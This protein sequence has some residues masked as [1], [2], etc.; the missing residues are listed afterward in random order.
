MTPIFVVSTGRCGST[1]LSDMIRR[2]PD[3]LSVS[4]F[5]TSL[6]SKAFVHSRAEWSGEAVYQRLNRLSPGGRALLKNGLYPDEFLYTRES[7]GRYR[8][9]EVP[10]ILCATLPHLSADSHEELWDELASVIRSRPGGALADHYRFVFEWLA[11]RFGKKT[12]IERS[13]G[14]LLYVPAL[15][16]LFPDARF[17]H[18]YRDGRDTAM[19]M[20][21]HP[22]FRLRVQAA[23]LLRR[24]GMNPFT[25][26]NV[27]GTSPWMPWFEWLRFQFFS[28]ER[29]RRMAIDPPSFGWFWSCAI[30]QGVDFLETLPSDRVLSMRYEAVVASPEQ[31]LRRFIRFVGHEFEDPDWLE[32]VSALPKARP[33]AWQRLPADEQARLAEACGPGQRRLGYDNA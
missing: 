33:Q 31:E 10:P 9:E 29:Y 3:L 26:F 27:P 4:E 8:P 5:F 11:H 20:Y 14:S 19:S 13:G 24:M 7:G 32:T 15:A 18:I 2:H 28:G 22:F 1:M 12:W 25:P 17:V 16:R 6:S 23:Q 30:E 21:R